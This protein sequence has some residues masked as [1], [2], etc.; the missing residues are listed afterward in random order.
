MELKLK[1]TIFDGKKIRKDVLRIF[2]KINRIQARGGASFFTLEENKGIDFQK[3]MEKNAEGNKIYFEKLANKDDTIDDLSTFLNDDEIRTI[4]GL[5]RY[6][7]DYYSEDQIKS[8]PVP[9]GTKIEQVV[10][11]DVPVEW[12][13]VPG[14][15]EEKVLLYFHGGGFVVGTPKYSRLLTVEIAK[16]TKLKILSVDYRLAPEHPFP[17]GLED[18]VTSYKWL[19]DEGYS[20][21]N[22]IIGGESA[23]GNLCIATLL[24]LRDEGINLPAGAFALSPVL[25]YTKE[26]QTVYKNAITDPILAD[27]GVFWWNFVHVKDTDPYNPYLSPI[28][29]DLKGLPPILLQVSKIEMLY[30]SS[31]RFYKRAMDA[32]VDISL[33]E[34]DEMVHVWQNF[35][36]NKLPEAKEAINK[37]GEFIKKLIN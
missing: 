23:G 34:W 33:Q 7:V 26:T 10:I 9:E 28:H 32:G 13:V 17:A 12:Q 20:P 21:K 4:V 30:D 22:I 31:T 1:M 3:I 36:L 18:G 35:G 24:K 29:A 11:N 37:I 2:Q 16:I 25:D 15:N 19:L 5:Y 8:N 27:V 6:G 14:A